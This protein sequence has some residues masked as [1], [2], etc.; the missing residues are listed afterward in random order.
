MSAG[1]HVHLVCIG[2]LLTRLL[3]TLCV[4]FDLLGMHSE[5][6]LQILPHINCMPSN[7]QQGMFFRCIVRLV[8]MCGKCMHCGGGA[9]VVVGL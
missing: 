9:N 7:Y 8:P 2:L 4:S 3:T 1:L 5:L 6:G